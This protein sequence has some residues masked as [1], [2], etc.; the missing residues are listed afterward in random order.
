MTVC[1]SKKDAHL[2]HSSVAEKRHDCL[3]S[4]ESC[5][6][7]HTGCVQY[8]IDCGAD[9]FKVDKTHSRS[10]LHYAVANGQ[11]KV[12]KYLVCEGTVM[13]TEEGLQSLRWIQVKDISGQ[14]RW[15][16]ALFSHPRHTSYWSA[17]MHSSM[18]ANK[19]F[20][21]WMVHE[22]RQWWPDRA[23]NRNGQFQT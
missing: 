13:H 4:R 20:I 1:L 9:V 21:L 23:Q 5:S 8:L 22:D 11:D 3:S 10:V 7:R 12:L 16:T 19:I 15:S 18:L 2:I 17:P 14:C 6:C